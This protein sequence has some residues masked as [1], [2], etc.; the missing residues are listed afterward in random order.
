[1]QKGEIRCQFVFSGKNKE[2]TPDFDTGFLECHS[3]RE[4]IPAKLVEE[5]RF[6]FPTPF[7]FLLGDEGNLI[8]HEGLT[9]KTSSIPSKIESPGVR[10]PWLVPVDGQ[11]SEDRP[12]I[13]LEEVDS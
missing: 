7:R 3:C 10:K 1:V 4:P 9:R 12:R 13:P 6:R 11:F 5:N 8:W 2:L